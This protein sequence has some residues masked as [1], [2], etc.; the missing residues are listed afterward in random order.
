M[1]FSKLGNITLL[2]IRVRLEVL[3]GAVKFQS[4]SG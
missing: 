2:L 4:P 1:V 3:I